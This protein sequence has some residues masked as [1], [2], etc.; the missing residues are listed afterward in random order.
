M[1]KWIGNLNWSTPS[2]IKLSYHTEEP[3]LSICM[4]SYLDTTLLQFWHPSFSCCWWTAKLLRLW[5]RTVWYQQG[6]CWLLRLQLLVVNIQKLFENS[7]SNRQQSSGTSYLR[8]GV[9]HSHT[10]HIFLIT[11]MDL[12]SRMIAPHSCTW[13]NAKF[14]STI[15][16]THRNLEYVELRILIPSFIWRIYMNL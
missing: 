11:A 3:H 13:R 8:Q 10:K 15:S 1:Q 9:L 12:E 4:P 2:P 6:I 16:I 7:H 5:R 14:L